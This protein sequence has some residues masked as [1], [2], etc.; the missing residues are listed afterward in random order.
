MLQTNNGR[1]P[2]GE[3]VWALAGFLMLLAFGDI[4]IVALLAVAAAALLTAW[5]VHRN[6]EHGAQGGDD[7]LA[8]VT[9]LHQRA[10]HQGGLSGPR[11]A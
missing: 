3:T 11:A 4:L 6:V 9:R 8:P 5:W 7:D 1:Y 2:I 10:P